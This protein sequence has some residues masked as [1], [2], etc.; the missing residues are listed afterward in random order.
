MLTVAS[1]IARKNL[2]ALDGAARRARRPG[3]RPRRGRGRPPAVPRRGA[4]PAVA[5]S[6]TCPTS[7]CPAST[8][9]RRLRAALALRG[10]RPAVPRG[11]GVRHAG[12]R[13][14]RRRAA[15]GLRRRRPL[16][17][18][19]DP[20]RSPTRSSARS[21]RAPRSASVRGPRRAEPSPG[22]PPPAASTPSSR[23]RWP[24]SPRD[25]LH[26]LQR[27]VTAHADHVGS[28]L[29]PPELL[30][31]RRVHT[32]PATSDD[33]AFKGIEATAL[34]STRSGCRRRPGLPVVTDGEFPP[35]VP[36]SPSWSPPSTAS[37]A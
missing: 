29:R 11:D 25:G 21:R 7:T 3:N 4:P 9:A 33:A 26:R 6:A 19:H 20:P 32:P 37:R 10:L 8:R 34:S 31:A 16:A 36:S 1:R 15:R 12:R 28:L 30:D 24:G 13:R 14:R 22:T 18:P 5:P 2:G 23:T 35:R 17:D 27:M